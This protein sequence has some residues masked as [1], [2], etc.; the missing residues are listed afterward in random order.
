MKCPVCGSIHHPEKAVL[1]EA[2]TDEAA[3]SKLR[4]MEAEARKKKDTA[5]TKA[6]TVR[7][8]LGEMERR[9]M[10][11]LAACL[12]QTDQPSDT[13]SID[14]L[15]SLTRR[16]RSEAVKRYDKNAK[17][18]ITLRKECGILERAEKDLR[19]ARG[20]ETEALSKKRQSLQ[21]A[22]RRC[23]TETAEKSAVLK[24][25]GTL[26]Y[27]CWDEALSA[28]TK[29][30]TEAKHI[31]EEA[32]NKAKISKKAQ[33]AVTRLEASI[34][35]R[36]KNLGALEKEEKKCADERDAALLKYGFSSD[37]EMLGLTATEKK[38]EKTEKE[39]R[40]YESR[41]EVN[42]AQLVRA[43]A[44]AEGKEWADMKAMA[45]RVKEL[46]R[47]LRKLS[48]IS[49]SIAYRI[50]TNAEKREGMERYRP[51]M[52]KAD[53]EYALC[54][55][56][57]NLVKGQTGNGR[58]TLEQY[59]QAAGFENI[60][61]AANRRLLPM[62][63]G[64]FELRRKSDAAGKKSSTFLDL[65]V[66]DNYTGHKRPVGTLSGGESFKASLSLALG[67]S[68]TVSSER[69]GIAMDALFV[70]EGFG[71]LDRRSIENAMD[72]LIRL[73]GTEK[74]VGIISHREELKENISQQIQVRKTAT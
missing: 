37:E 48:D 50:R 62:S 64:Q 27:D 65:E 22:R 9:L 25:A 29:M 30:R 49:G 33:D 24:A 15:V 45:A 42:A 47:E 3:V 67:L 51:E 44:E 60:I 1:P 69:G 53:H 8:A 66:L 28:I 32:E 21:E 31:T 52:E 35:T 17:K 39:I 74:L 2:H 18:I 7:S 12:P 20:E 13:L 16:A 40:E 55:R 71:T 56:L 11:D 26:G 54:R 34:A 63:E 58:I 6:E 41:A 43:E 5:L 57:Y 23:D 38:I 4:K 59:V 36:R 10:S 68:D 46:E 72:T 73:S 19:A 70:D 14:E 61:S